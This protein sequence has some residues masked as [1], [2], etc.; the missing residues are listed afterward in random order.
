MGNLFIFSC[1][2]IAP[3]LA[4]PFLRGSD[5]RWQREYLIYI[6]CP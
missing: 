3:D 4:F 6:Q 2:P 1:I 5:E